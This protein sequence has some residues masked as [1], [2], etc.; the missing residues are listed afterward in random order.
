MAKGKR[1]SDD[2]RWAIVRMAPFMDI[3][4][5]A[6]FTNVSRRQILRILTLHR[7]MGEVSN[8]PDLRSLPRE[9]H[10]SAEDVSVS[11]HIPY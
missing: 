2:L 5:I 4:A 10:L 8:G 11:P 9:R 7:S 1:I 3:S 6:R